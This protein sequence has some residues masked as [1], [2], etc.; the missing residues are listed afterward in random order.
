MKIFSSALQGIVLFKIKLMHLCRA[1]YIKS[2]Q[3]SKKF[4]QHVPLD[5]LAEQPS[6]E[7]WMNAELT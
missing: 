2:S 1:F 6:R 4:Y 3:F 7:R 5:E